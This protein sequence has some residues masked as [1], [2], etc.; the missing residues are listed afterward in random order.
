MQVTCG[1]IQ[2]LYNGGNKRRSSSTVFKRDSERS[3][4]ARGVQL[5]VL[6]IQALF[7]SFLLNMK[8]FCLFV[9]VRCSWKLR[10][11]RDWKNINCK[12][13]QFA[14][15]GLDDTVMRKSAS[16]CFLENLL[17]ILW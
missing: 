17:Y 3:F 4:M 9:L 11:H 5:S 8:F 2:L 13:G 16:S 12:H 10:I 14:K 1:T 7:T 15:A 6:D